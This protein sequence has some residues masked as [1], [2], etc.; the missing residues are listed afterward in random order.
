MKIVHENKACLILECAL[1][2]YLISKLAP[3]PL[4]KSYVI[5]TKIGQ[6]NGRPTP[7][8]DTSPTGRRVKA[9]LGTK[10][11]YYREMV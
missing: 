7:I 9:F 1:D 11:N 10:I 8:Y 4:N 5:G 2:T 6:Y 3:A